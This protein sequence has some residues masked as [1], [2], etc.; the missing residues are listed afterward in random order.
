MLNGNKDTPCNAQPQGPLCIQQ[1]K[2][3]QS[4]NFQV[5]LENLSVSSPPFG[6]SCDGQAGKEGIGK[7]GLGRAGGLSWLLLLVCATRHGHACNAR[8]KNP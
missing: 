8:Q 7:V 3:I 4:D 1:A 5:Y 6:G 2:A